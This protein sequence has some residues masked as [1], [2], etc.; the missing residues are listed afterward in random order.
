MALFISVYFVCSFVYLFILFVRLFVNFVRSFVCLSLGVIEFVIVT[1]FHVC[2]EHRLL[3]FSCLYFFQQ[4]TKTT[5][6]HKIEYIFLKKD[7]KISVNRAKT[8]VHELLL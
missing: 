8:C 2:T 3:V 7:Y 4:N 5:R 1:E 6:A